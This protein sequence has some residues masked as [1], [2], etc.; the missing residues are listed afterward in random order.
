MHNEGENT[1]SGRNDSAQVEEGEDM[2][3]LSNDLCARIVFGYDFK[4]GSRSFSLTDIP[5]PTST[6]P[7]HPVL[8]T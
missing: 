3:Y 2:V 1:A 4:L 6:P 7:L 8:T 5:I